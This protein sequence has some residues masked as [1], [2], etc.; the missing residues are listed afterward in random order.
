MACGT[1]QRLIDWIDGVDNVLQDDDVVDRLLRMLDG[2]VGR[3][4][5]ELPK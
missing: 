1:N 3:Y 5:D 2:R 4:R